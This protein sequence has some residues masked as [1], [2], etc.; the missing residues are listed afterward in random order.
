ME[1]DEGTTCIKEKYN[2]RRKI[3]PLKLMYI[4]NNP[5]VAEIAQ[6]LGVDRIWVDMEYIGK[7]ERQKG[8]NTVKSHHNIED[9]Q[10]IHSVITTSELLVRVNPL[11]EVCSEYCSSKDEIDQTIAHGA[12]II[13]LPMFKTRRDVE[14][15]IDYVGGRAKVLLLLETGEADENIEDIVTVPGIDEIHIGLNDLHLIYRKKFMFELLADG[16]VDRLCSIIGNKGIK[17]GFG[18]I[19]RLDEGLLPAR[20]ILGE[21]YR[22]GSS[23]AILSRSF[24]DLWVE[25]DMEEIERVFRFGI[26]EIREYENRLSHESTE[27]FENNHKL[28]KHQ[29]ETIVEKISGKKKV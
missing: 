7:E 1:N 24:Y 14:Q 17:Y 27:F 29:V 6:R 9:I 11:H 26:T 16:T 19:A 10:R 21:H 8:M 25:N 12:D 22:L 15:F 23:M 18:G 4:T 13:M 28:L 5:K 20:Q 2:F 3:M